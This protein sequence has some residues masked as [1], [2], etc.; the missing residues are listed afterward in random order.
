M[1]GDVGMGDRR[2]GGEGN[3]LST[4]ILTIPTTTRDTAEVRASFWV[5]LG[6]KEVSMIMFNGNIATPTY[7]TLCTFPMRF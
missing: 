7:L 6:S 2:E 4:Y 5:S 1:M 3:G